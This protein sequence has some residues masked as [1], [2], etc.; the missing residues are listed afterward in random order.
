MFGIG[1][2]L[3]GAEIETIEGMANRVLHLQ[4]KFQIMPRFSAE[5]I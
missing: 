3:D 1:I 4:Q 2:E 5:F